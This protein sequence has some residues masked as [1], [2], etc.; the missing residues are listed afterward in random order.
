MGERLQSTRPFHIVSVPDNDQ[1]IN[2]L[3]RGWGVNEVYA[4]TMATDIW[5][6][7]LLPRRQIWSLL[8]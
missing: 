2:I 5:V 8:G 6:G 4:A 1:K 7:R 3:H